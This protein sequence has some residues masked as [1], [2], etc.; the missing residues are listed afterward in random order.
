MPLPV[1]LIRPR[2]ITGMSAVLLPF[3]APG[4]VDWDAFE[5]HVERTARS[6]L[7]PAV[8]M[9]TGYAHLLDD[10]TK[11]EAPRRA[12]PRPGA[13]FGA[14]AFNPAEARAVRDLGGTPV[15]VPNDRLAGDVLDCYRQV[16]AEVDRFI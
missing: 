2:R 9:D 14:G 5:G 1:D 12:A 16:A 11:A 15:L 13:A 8:N 3:T 10:R 6:G 7:V 4:T